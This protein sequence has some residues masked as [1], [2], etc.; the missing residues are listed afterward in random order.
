VN[1]CTRLLLP[2]MAVAITTLLGACATTQGPASVPTTERSGQSWVVTRPIIAAQ[3]LDTCSRP[4]PGREAGRVSGYWAPSRQQVDQLEAK[5][6]TLET[7]VPHVMDF[8]RQYVGIELDGK[9]VI[10]IN[11][12]HLPEDNRL[13]PAREAVRVC[14]GGAQF[15]GAVFDPASGTFNEL[16]FNGGFGGP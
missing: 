7:Q 8:D 13:R 10:Y 16:Q 12:F 15:W 11:A 5:L 14:D 1:R 3:V 6:A 9:R 2:S 4:S